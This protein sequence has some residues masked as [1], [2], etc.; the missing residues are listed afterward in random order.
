MQVVPVK[1]FMIGRSM[2]PSM[3]R[4]WITII[5][6]AV[7]AIF[8]AGCTS[9]AAGLNTVP[10]VETQEYRLVSGDK[11]RIS[12]PDLQGADGEYL[13]DQ[14][15][16]VSLPLVQ[17][18][19]VAGLTLREAEGAITKVILDRSILVRPTVTIQAV[20]LRPVYILGEVNKPGEYSFRDG[21][22]IFSIV[23]M[24][25]GYTYR[26]NT[27]SVTITRSVNGRMTTG[28]AGE[29]TVVMPGDQI[30]VVEKWF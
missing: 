1:L 15:G 24:A 8:A 10:A 27:K 17:E 25:G 28:K 22:T 9:A 6:M 13:I 18:V 14:T 12:V 16:T 30:R 2:M 5:L 4:S 23:S 19:K 7:S 11:I 26:A 29:N 21:L 3:F 20:G